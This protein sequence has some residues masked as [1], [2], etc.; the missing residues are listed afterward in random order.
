M[1]F[2]STP[3]KPDSGT[4][5]W[6]EQESATLCWVPERETREA[7]QLEGCYFFFCDSECFLSWL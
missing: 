5:Q 7:R 2:F 1:L 4:C 3:H 6:C